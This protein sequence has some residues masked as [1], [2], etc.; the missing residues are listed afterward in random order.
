VNADGLRRVVL[1]TTCNLSAGRGQE[2]SR[3]LESL[4][5]A[6]Q[7]GVAIRHHLLLQEWDPCGAALALPPWVSCTTIP[8]RLGISAARNV[9][10]RG[11]RAEFAD[12]DLVAFPD[13][14]AWYP[15]G[16]LAGMCALLDRFPRAGLVVSAYS[17]APCAIPADP[18]LSRQLGNFVRSS[19]ANNLFV[20]GRAA[21]AAGLFDEQLGL[22]APV[23]GGEDLDYALRVLAASG[24][25]PLAVT[26]PLVGHRDPA[27]WARSRYFAGSL[28]A[29][30]RARAD[31]PGARAQYL[32]KLLV[33][34]AMAMRGEL[35][36]GAALRAVMT[37]HRAARSPAPE[38]LPDG[39][40]AE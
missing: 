38:S 18:P 23:N 30:I 19:S 4:E 35:R 1:L 17:S 5:P 31:V 34:V 13:D 33:G 3:L 6:L 24:E 22:G 11:A 15:P 2:L 10:V 12:A 27:P 28:T 29:L 36:P 14:D 25:A 26:L 21:G 32:R 16:L 39:R 20:R 9:L 8:G 7:P 37:A 40:A